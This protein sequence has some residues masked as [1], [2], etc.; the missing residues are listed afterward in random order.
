MV[1]APAKPPATPQPPGNKPRP[2]PPQR[3]PGSSGR[4]P[5]RLPLALR[6]AI[7]LLVVWHFTGVFLAALSVGGSSALVTNIAQGPPMQWYLDA[8][9]M[10]QGHSFFAP[11]VG[12]GQIIEYELFDQS[13]RLVEQGGLPNRKEHWPR[14]RYHRHFML[15]DQAGIPS[16][17]PQYRDYW[18]RK[19]LESYADHLLRTHDDA[20]SVRVLRKVHWPIP[21]D[22]ALQGRKLTDP[23]SYQTVFQVTRQR[24]ALRPSE[25]DHTGVFYLQHQQPYRQPQRLPSTAQRWIGVP[26]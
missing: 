20:E 15:A 10:N 24:S 3:E 19:Y 12:P 25:R 17:N 23:E 16:D 21:R 26:R 11:E 7:S 14:L 18:Q 13:G 6:V 2:T 9:Y 22:F 4:R 5:G 1:G 8:L